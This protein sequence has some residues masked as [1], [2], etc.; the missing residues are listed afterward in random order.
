MPLQDDFE[1]F[2]FRLK[3]KVE[4]VDMWQVIQCRVAFL[5]HVSGEAFDSSLPR[6][7]GSKSGD[8]RRNPSLTSSE[9]WRR[10]VISFKICGK[11]QHPIVPISKLVILSA[12]LKSQRGIH[13][14]STRLS[15]KQSNSSVKPTIPTNFSRHWMLQLS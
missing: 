15:L 4:K 5:K 8:F 14:F 10:I 7:D 6:P 13:T 1:S 9:F 12:I 3:T 11:N 2:K